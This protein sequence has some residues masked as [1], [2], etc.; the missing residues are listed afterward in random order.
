MPTC[1][2]IQLCCDPPAA[3]ADLA[4]HEQIPL[5]AAAKILAGYQLIPRKIEAGPGPASAEHV[6]LA[7][8]R[9]AKLHA[10]SLLELKAIL[11]DMGHDVVQ[12]RS[13]GE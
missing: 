1:C 11:I 12:T 4:A 6:E 8:K 3:A 13:A 7:R 5:E 10:R 9:L 2:R